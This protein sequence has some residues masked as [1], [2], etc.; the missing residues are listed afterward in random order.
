LNIEK[1][2]VRRQ[3]RSRPLDCRQRFFT[4][5]G[6]AHDFDFRVRREQPPQ[7]LPRNSFVVDDESFHKIAAFMLRL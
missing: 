5:A 1:N 3:I 7:L 2:D 6:F 4:I